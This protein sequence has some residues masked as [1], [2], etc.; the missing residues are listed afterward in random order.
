MI[1]VVV[2]SKYIYAGTCTYH[3][4]L[5]ILFCHY[6]SNGSELQQVQLVVRDVFTVKEC[7]FFVF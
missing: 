4:I 2:S 1:Q 7:I 6:M 5:V 3:F